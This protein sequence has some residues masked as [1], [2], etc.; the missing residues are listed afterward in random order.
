M[1]LFE[2]K[3]VDCVNYVLKS[4]VMS[5]F[6]L[7]SNNMYLFPDEK[8]NI[9]VLFVLKSANSYFNWKKKSQN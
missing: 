3:V 4:N 8:V 7:K 1:Y 2:Q 5:L 6:V 9:Y